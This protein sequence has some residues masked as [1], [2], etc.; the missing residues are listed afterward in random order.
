V[1]KKISENIM[2]IGEGPEHIIYRSDCGCGS[3]DHSQT[4][5]LD[6]DEDFGLGMRLYADIDVPIYYGNGNMFSRAWLRVKYA[7]RLLFTGNI[8]MESD[9]LFRGAGHIEDYI[10][11]LQQGLDK[12]KERD[13]KDVI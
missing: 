1:C 2:K 12:L 3:N 10:T 7:F 11:A 8:H 4:L 5:F 9:F 6:L 13:R